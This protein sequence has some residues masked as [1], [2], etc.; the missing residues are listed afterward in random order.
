MARSGITA[1]MA[2]PSE[3]AINL[4]HLAAWLVVVEERSVTAAA[5]RLSISQPA[6]SQQL[7]MLERRLGVQ[8]LERLP[9]G[10]QP[11]AAGRALMHDARATLVAAGRLS[12]QAQGIVGLRG[13]FLEIA[14]LPSLVDSTLLSP[15]RE[16]HTLHP[17]VAVHLHEFPQAGDMA[18]AVAMGVGDIGVGVRPGAWNGPIVSLGWEQFVAV[19]PPGDPAPPA[20][21][22]IDL[23]TLADREWVLY[24][25]TQGL[26]D[27]VE[28]ACAQAG[29]RPKEAVSTS[30]VHAA[31]R[32]ALAG[33]GPA[34]VPSQ[35]VP[36]ELAHA[37][38]PLDPP[39]IWEIVAYA[40]TMI[41]PA[42]AIFVDLVRGEAPLQPAENALV[43]PAA[44]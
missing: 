3:L 21:M 39:V 6:L 23:R 17:D 25:T 40:R 9:G 29:F 43:L 11:T 41:S 28:A 37:A 14:T 42:A 20:R 10:V 27:Y 13:G 1:A 36:P 38:H 4:R 5:K 24:A 30:Q 34:L 18:E 44:A 19:L 35:N 7:R 26:S 31:A 12:D 32:L 2:L 22:P 33:L 16:W 8:L 15:L